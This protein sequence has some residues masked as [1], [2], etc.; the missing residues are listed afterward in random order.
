ML[1]VQ[2]SFFRDTVCSAL[3][4]TKIDS[5]LRCSDVFM[6]S[7]QDIKIFS[8]LAVLFVHIKNY[9]LCVNQGLF[10]TLKKIIMNPKVHLVVQFKCLQGIPKK[11][12]LLYLKSLQTV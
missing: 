2:T 10:A 4:K 12:L 1:F 11:E 5:Q 9:I 6:S 7:K 3:K 8:R